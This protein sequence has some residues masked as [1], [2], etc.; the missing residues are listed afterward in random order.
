MRLKIP[1]PTAAYGDVRPSVGRVLLC[2]AAVGV[3]VALHGYLWHELPNLKV[4]EMTLH[5]QPRRVQTEPMRLE[6]VRPLPDLSPYVQP[7]RF[8]PENPDAFEKVGERQNDLL[9]EF[10]ESAGATVYEVAAPAP[11]G[12]AP[13]ITMDELFETSPENYRQEIL[14]IEQKIAKDELAALPRKVTA[15][16]ERVQGAPDITLS[17]SPELVARAAQAASGGGSPAVLPPAG[18]VEE[19]APLA[20]ED[21]AVIESMPTEQA[22]AVFEADRDALMDERPAEVTEITPI[23]DRLVLHTTAWQGTDDDYIYFEV[24]IARSGEQALPVLPKDVLIVQDCSESI[25]R[26]KLEFFKEAIEDYLRTLTTVDRF[27]IMRYDETATTC[28]PDWAPATS[29]NL[30]AG[31]RFVRGM[32]LHGRT[33]LYASLQQILRVTRSSSRPMIVLLL[34][35][36]RP[37]M[38]LMDNSDIISRFTRLNQ[39]NVSVFTIGAGDSV[40]GFL[41]DML[42]QNNRGGTWTGADRAQIPDLAADAAKELSRPCLM[43]L[44]YRMS[45]N[46]PVE[47]YPPALTHLYVDRPLKLVGRVPSSAAGGVLQVVGTSAGQTFDMVFPIEL[48]EAG[49]GSEAIRRDWARQK[50][51]HLLNANLETKNAAAEAEARRIADEFHVNMGW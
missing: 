19:P 18:Q 6:E 42:G 36:G 22:T 51:Y 43:N 3:S 45:G 32:K 27:N 48:D 40:N 1:P 23:E 25:T 8:R 24:E 37:T 12:A 46:W 34:T 26:S 9:D 20:P 49:R 21:V 5:V 11:A 38:G 28:F 30:T 16:A 47:I 33:D 31:A 2:V 14:E 7:T 4:G 50:I 10:I 41:L 13:E 15:K 29:E 44:T 39:G 35:D 17:A